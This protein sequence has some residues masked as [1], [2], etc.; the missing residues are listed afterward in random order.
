MGPPVTDNSPVMLLINTPTV[1]T[2]LFKYFH[3]SEK[4]PLMT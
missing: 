2:K 3:A 4:V 1:I